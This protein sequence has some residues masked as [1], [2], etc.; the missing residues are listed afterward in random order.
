MASDGITRPTMARESLAVA[1]F[2]VLALPIVVAASSDQRG[3]GEMCINDEH[4]SLLGTCTPQGRCKCLPGWAGYSC[5]R[6]D[7]APL[8][9]TLGYHNATES[10]WG[11]R[12]VKDPMSGKW[13]LFAT[14][15]KNSCPLI[16][17]EYNSQVIRAESDSGEIGGP[18]TKA[19][20]VL[21]P[22]HHNPTIVG[23]SPDGYFLMF[24]I[25]ASN[26][27]FLNGTLDPILDCREAVPNVPLPGKTK[28]PL[29]SNRYITMATTKDVVNGPWEQRV[30]LRDDQPQYN[31]SSWHCSENNPSASILANGTVV[32]VYRANPCAKDAVDSGEHLGIAVADHWSSNFVRDTFPIVSPADVNLTHGSNNEDPFIFHMGDGSWHIVNHQ[33]GRTNVCGGS[34]QGHSCGAHF[35]AHNPHGPWMM[36]PEPVYSE[37]V[38]LTNGSMARF[39]TRQRPQLVFDDAMVP[40]FLFTSGSFDGNNPDLNMSTHTF[41]HAFV[42]SVE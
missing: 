28:S 17:F 4:C 34:E 30:I 36:S 24:F 15:I 25:G 8:D 19:D 32:V 35:F 42:N 27:T 20:V 26:A 12:P 10:S 5:A 33:Q 40:L 13:N 21:P 18:Y 16:L 3:V 31:Q 2:T 9:I 23:P 38:T 1:V 11:G 41:A 6:A 22:F 37:N 14:E 7:L 39:Q 29:T